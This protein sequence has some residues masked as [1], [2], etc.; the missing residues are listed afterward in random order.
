[1]SFIDHY[2]TRLV[3]AGRR[4]IES[5]WRNRMAR[6]LRMPRHRNAAIL[7]AALL[8]G[9]PATAATVGWNPFDDPGRVPD[10]SPTTSMQAP[11]PALTRILAPL[12]RPQ[13]PADRGRATSLAAQGFW[14]DVGGVQLDYIR[15]LDKARGIVV[16]PVE[17]FGL[18]LQRHTGTPPRPAD[19]ADAVCL[20]V[21]DTAGM[22]RRP[23]YTAKRI[24]DGFAVSTGSGGAVIAIVPDGVAA[25]RFSRGARSVEAPVR[26]NLVVADSP[27]PAAIDWLDASGRAIKRIDLTDPR[28]R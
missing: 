7:L 27:A 2:Q 21:P 6:W 25:V 14:D 23:C 28:P 15:V 16:V 24:A 12:R 3:D 19:F 20:Y 5:R 10:S 13:S 4:R 17:R 26:D 22:A 1:M 18:A 9:A 11:A 8:V